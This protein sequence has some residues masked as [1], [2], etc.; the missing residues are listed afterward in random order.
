[1][2]SSKTFS[3][4]LNR[5]ATL[6]CE[7][8]MFKI[9]AVVHACFF[10]IFLIEKIEKEL[11]CCVWLDSAHPAVISMWTVFHSLCCW[12]GSRK[13]IWPVKNWVLGCWHSYP[14]GV[15]CRLAYGPA[16]ATA[17]HCLLLLDSLSLGF[18]VLVPAHL[19]SP[20][21]SA[22]KRVCVCVQARF[23][24]T[25]RADVSVSVAGVNRHRQPAC[26]GDDG[27]GNEQRRGA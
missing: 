25:V 14:S 21:Q 23:S 15:R 4:H 1:M 27:G 19:D 20:G 12:L 24:V 5:V 11:A 18:T 16:D 10:N 13:G 6:S 2:K 17:T 22:V 8:W 3:P 9:T 7:M 26:D